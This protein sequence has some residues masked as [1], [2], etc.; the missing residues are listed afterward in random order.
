MIFLAV[1]LSLGL[2]S[3][4]G[5]QAQT[6]TDQPVLLSADWLTHD[7]NSEI[8]TAEGHVELAQSGR[9]LLADRVIY[10]QRRDRVTASGNV[11]ILEPSGEV[12]FADAVELTD[13]M[14]NGV[15][16]N[17][18]LLLTDHSRLAANGAR[19]TDGVRTVMRKAIYS[20]CALCADDPSDAPLW[21]LKAIRVVHDQEDRMIEYSDVFMEVYGIPVMYMPYFAH[22]DPS[23]RRKNGFLAPSYG[24][25]STLGFNVTTPYFWNIQPHRDFTFS[26][27]FTSKEGVVLAGEY[28]EHTGNG[29]Y[30]LGGSWT[31]VDKRGD[32]GE[33]TGGEET[34]GHIEGDG[35]FAL[36]PAWMWGFDLS[37]ATDDTYR[38]RYG[39]GGEDTLTTD[40]WLQ[41]QEGRRF[42]SLTGYWFQGLEENDDAS[43][44]PLILPVFDY[45]FISDPSSAGTWWSVNANA[46]VLARS[47]GA[48]SRRLSTTGAW[49][50]RYIG[51]AG[52]IYNFSASLRGDLYWVND[53]ANPADPN[54]TSLAGVTGRVIPEVTFGWR[55]PW[56][57][58]HESVRQVIEPIVT[59]IVSPYGGNLDK[60]PNEDSVDFE[61]DDTNLFSSNRFTGLDR[62]EGGPRV[63]YGV[64]WGLYGESGGRTTAL[65]GQSVRVKDD[66]TFGTGTGL[67]KNFSDYVGRI[68]VTPTDYLD[69]NYRF[70]LDRENFTAQRN[71]VSASIGPAYL[72]LA[73]TYLQ[74]ESE[75]STGAESEFA[76]REEV[77]LVGNVDLTEFWTFSL[78]HRRSLIDDGGSLNSGSTLT[79]ED[80]CFFFRLRA[81]RRF[82]EDRDA[83][84]ETTILF[85]IQFKHLG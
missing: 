45:E 32:D 57:A 60:I 51:A 56:I 76:S 28:R 7:R 49:H 59:A 27:I 30:R 65:L 85:T 11:S 44:I 72:N 83:E 39:F 55:Y 1:T 69:I 62:V 81:N 66:S 22:P 35:R 74:L 16:T 6:A 47:V 73:A 33:L 20:P 84:P 67:E 42:V 43:K 82:T 3:L 68:A 79:Y 21:Q 78:D 48:H 5:A 12:L 38:S 29:I 10:D 31:H 80:E 24:S 75:S 37:R 40:L 19:R 50:L 25:S 18:R 41:G 23:V 13:Q 46:L 52:D 61:F 14:K 63:N 53:V 77:S 9:I 58:Q 70:R 15:I 54:T 26:P 2:A 34:R 4:S 8:V 17:I 36:S 71:E 64:R